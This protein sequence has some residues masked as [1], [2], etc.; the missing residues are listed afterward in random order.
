MITNSDETQFN[1]NAN[2]APPVQSSSFSSEMNQV[3]PPSSAKKSSSLQRTLAKF[4]PTTHQEK[5]MLEPTTA[6]TSGKDEFFIE[7][8]IVP[9]NLPPR[10]LVAIR[11]G[12]VRN[13]IVGNNTPRKIS[14]TAA[15]I[16][17]SPK[18]SSWN[19]NK[20]A[21][22]DESKSSTTPKP[23]KGFKKEKKSMSSQLTN[24]DLKLKSVEGSF[25]RRM[26][27]FVRAREDDKM[28]LKD[29]I[30]KVREEGEERLNEFVRE[31]EGDREKINELESLLNRASAEN[32]VVRKKYHRLGEQLE[33]SQNE[34]TVNTH[35]LS[36]EEIVEVR[37]RPFASRLC[38]EENAENNDSN[39]VWLESHFSDRHRMKS[40]PQRISDCT[41][42]MG[43]TKNNFGAC[44]NLGHLM[45]ELFD[46]KTAKFHSIAT[47]I[48]S[49]LSENGSGVTFEQGL[50]SQESSKKTIP[51]PSEQSV[52]RMQFTRF[53][54]IIFRKVKMERQLLKEGKSNIYRLAYCA[55]KYPRV[56][57]EERTTESAMSAFSRALVVFTSQA[58]LT[59]YIVL[60]SIDR[61]SDQKVHSRMLPLAC[62]VLSLS[63]LISWQGLSSIAETHNFY[64]GNNSIEFGNSVKVHAGHI[65]PLALLDYISN[66]ILPIFL[67]VSSFVLISSQERYIE[68]I[69]NSIALLFILKIHDISSIIFKVDAK[70]IVHNHLIEEAV[71]EVKDQ[72]KYLNY[73]TSER[74]NLECL[75]S[76]PDSKETTVES[77]SDEVS[78]KNELNVVQNTAEALVEQ[79]FDGLRDVY[80]TPK[81]EFA[82]MLLT[83]P[84]Q[85]GNSKNDNELYTPYKIFG[86]YDEPEFIASNY[87]T[88]NCLFKSV[89]WSYSTNDPLSGAP[90]IVFLRLQKLNGEQNAYVM[91]MHDTFC[92]NHLPEKEKDF[93]KEDVKSN[94]TVN[95]NNVIYSRPVVSF[96]DDSDESDTEQSE[97]SHSTIQADSGNQ[98]ELHLMSQTDSIS[99][100]EQPEITSNAEAISQ[101][102]ASLTQE[103]D[104]LGVDDG[105][106]QSSDN[107]KLQM[108]EDEMNNIVCKVKKCDDGSISSQSSVVIDPVDIEKEDVHQT[109]VSEDQTTDLTQNGAIEKIDEHNG[110]VDDIPQK[111]EECNDASTSS[112]SSVAIDPVEI[113][114]SVHVLSQQSISDSCSKNNMLPSTIVDPHQPINDPFSD[115]IMSLLD[116]CAHSDQK[117]IIEKI[118]E[119]NPVYKVEGIYMITDF[120]CTESITKLRICGSKTAENFTKAMETY[121][122]WKLD[123]NTKKLLRQR[124]LKGKT[125]TVG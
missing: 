73:D 3:A 15:R 96:F 108:D 25:G 7:G 67:M 2:N 79:N 11:K 54:H 23:E 103:N 46:M 16:M 66:L 91:R 14:A 55:S 20:A 35:P 32:E 61:I 109:I 10:N 88:E 106:L 72:Q 38:I 36:I 117:S 52:S 105:V 77:K 48:A 87:I 115:K 29:E 120:E 119:C 90:R 30:W 86:T 37:K 63:F 1:N 57:E 122:L 47:T 18:K 92:N 104:A 4:T 114:E 51:D 102:T 107:N 40:F 101:S 98:L 121:S 13:S 99:Q 118:E 78:N 31:R 50:Y 85:G 22:D 8:G 123:G 62:L 113:I 44:N 59:L 97:E 93:V 39:K 80:S 110:S 6:T 24:L 43:L 28:K 21:D 84:V 69:M 17:P 9:N 60:E 83:N 94:I 34:G 53:M 49:A 5:K 111:M 112:Q 45:M 26:D 89:E 27:G 65:H 68:A 12:P 100:F 56:T 41:R 124:A 82:D 70:K 95:Q 64:R 19:K 125:T 75:E 81:I 116:D 71:V 33:N 42:T 74:S 76:I 58:M